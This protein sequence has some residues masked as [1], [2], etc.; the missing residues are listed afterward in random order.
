MFTDT[1]NLFYEMKIADASKD[2]YEKKKDQ[3]LF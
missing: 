3:N 1:D 2:L